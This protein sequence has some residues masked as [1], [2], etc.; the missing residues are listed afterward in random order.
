MLIQGDSMKKYFVNGFY[1]ENVSNLLV[2]SAVFPLVRDLEYSFNLKVVGRHDLND[3]NVLGT[4]DPAQPLLMA[5]EEGIA[6][7]VAFCRKSVKG[8]TE[9]CFYSG[10]KSKDRGRNDTDRRTYYAKKV[11]QLIRVLDRSKVIDTSAPIKK[12]LNTARCVTNI[13]AS[14]FKTNKEKDI[15]VESLHGLLKAVLN[16]DKSNINYDECKKL[17]D[18]YNGVDKLRDTKAKE[19]QRFFGGAFHMIGVDY[20]GHFIV[21]KARVEDI[22]SSLNNKMLSYEQFSNIHIIEPFK[23]YRTIEER[24]DLIPLMTMTKVALQGGEEGKLYSG[25]IPR[26]SK[27]MPELDVVYDY[28]GQFNALNPIWMCAPA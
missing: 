24:E 22:Y 23:R 19:L 2:N 25:Y 10:F 13:M 20:C 16:G 11:S 18:I 27:Y 26:S 6:L 7:G 21:G 28:D 9:Y 8:E 15:D 17:L 4:T 1:D 5:N 12:F 14:H 3:S